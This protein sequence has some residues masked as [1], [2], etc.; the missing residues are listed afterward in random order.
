MSHLQ[1]RTTFQKR[2]SQYGIHAVHTK[3]ISYKMF[4]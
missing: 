2:T 1:L 4:K 3:G